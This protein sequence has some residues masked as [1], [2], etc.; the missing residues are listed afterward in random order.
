MGLAY[1][2]HVNTSTIVR[3]VKL[4]RINNPKQV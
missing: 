1:T 4:E 2:G 3:V